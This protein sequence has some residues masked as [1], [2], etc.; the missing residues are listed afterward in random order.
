MRVLPLRGFGFEEGAERGAI[1]RRR[2]LPV[3]LDRIPALA[4]SFDIGVAVLRDER[5]DTLRVTNGKA[6]ANGRAVV[7]NVK[8]IALEPKHFGKTV[9][10]VGKMIEA[11][12][13]ALAVR[14]IRESEARK[15]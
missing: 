1:F 12:F 10:D 13:K 11:V 2:I 6:E 9:D 15:V 4:Q 7:E 3:S 5:G 8:G 14:R